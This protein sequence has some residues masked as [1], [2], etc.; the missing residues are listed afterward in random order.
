[1]ATNFGTDELCGCGD[2]DC[3]TCFPG[4][5]HF[6][7][8]E[9]TGGAWWD[10]FCCRGCVEKI[11]PGETAE[12]FDFGSFIERTGCDVRT[13]PDFCFNCGDKLGV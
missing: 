7:G 1:M 9:L 10:L 3:R 12:Y 11:H 6:Y 13:K 5:R 8:I 4:P 2:G